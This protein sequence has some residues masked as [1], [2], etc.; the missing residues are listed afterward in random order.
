MS[1]RESAQI[2]PGAWRLALETPTL[3]PATATNT[4]VLGHDRLVVIEPATP[5]AGEQARLDALLDELLGEGRELAAILLTHHHAD[6]VAYAPLLRARHGAPIITHA[7][8]AARLDFPVDETFER[9]WSLALGGGHVVEALDTPG[10]VTGHQLFWD[11]QTGIAHAGDLVAGEGTVLIDIRDGGDMREYLDSLT[12]MAA[13]VRDERAEGRTPRFVPAHGPVLD[14]PLAVLDY[15]LR[16]RLEREDKV[17]K[18]VVED[19]RR[20]F[21]AILAAAYADTPK[22][23]WPFAAL[24]LEA[25]LRKLV[26]DGELR[27]VG[28][29]ARPV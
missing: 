12:R 20:V 14:D 8:T 15:Y 18:A 2:A 6:H 3:P 28:K 13:R 29:G 11:R 27:R 19:G 23:A 10:H 17:R 1:A 16:H 5:H 26:D 9:G 22:R 25:H 7:Q 24:A 4:L 21:P